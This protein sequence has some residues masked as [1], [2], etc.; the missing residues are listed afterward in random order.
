M[1]TPL[2]CTFPACCILS[3][4]LVMTSSSS[5]ITFGNVIVLRN[6]SNVI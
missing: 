3:N 4:S 2:S 5:S 6:F 1:V